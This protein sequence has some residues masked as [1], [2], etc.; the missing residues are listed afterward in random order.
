MNTV[1]KTDKLPDMPEGISPECRDFIYSC[2]KRKPNER[3]N[4]C[5]LLKHSFIKNEKKTTVFAADLDQKESED[6]SEPYNFFDLKFEANKYRNEPGEDEE[7]TDIHIEIPFVMN[8]H[9]NGPDVEMD[10]DAS[11]TQPGIPES[12]KKSKPSLRTARNNNSDHPLP[13]ETDQQT[14][15]SKSSNR[16]Y[17]SSKY[18]GQQ[19]TGKV[20]LKLKSS[21]NTT[22]VSL[23]I[24]GLG[25]VRS[26]KGETGRKHG[27]DEEFD[28]GQSEPTKQVN[29]HN[30]K[31]KLQIQSSRGPKI[32]HPKFIKPPDPSTS[33]QK[34]G[35]M[36]V[37]KPPMPSQ[38][39]L[40]EKKPGAA[41][42]SRGATAS[43]SGFFGGF[44]PKEKAAKKAGALPVRFA[45]KNG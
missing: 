5:Q 20:K 43:H 33:P 36:S 3:M 25:A 18:V 19:T 27:R 26:Q 31:M 39:N 28:F 23:Q 30:F 15:F 14:P 44:S 12:S 21:E 7:G 37:P 34:R 32:S 1:V 35:L 42:A 16:T 38:P 2:L 6:A 41:T 24:T 29:V 11:G 8:D 22:A 9:N 45:E 17:S 40:E 10:Q 13:T 4:V